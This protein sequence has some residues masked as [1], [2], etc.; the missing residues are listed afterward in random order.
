MMNVQL[1]PIYAG[2]PEDF[3][4]VGFGSGTGTNLREC[5]KVIKPSLIVCDRPKADLL[6]LEELAEVPRIVINGYER[7]GSWKKAQGNPDA[8]AAY[9]EKS[10]VLDR[11]FRDAIYEFEGGRGIELHLAVLGGWMRFI[12]A[13]LLDYF[14][15]RMINVHPARLDILGITNKR[16]FVGDDAVYLAIK[17]GQY[18]TRSSVIIVDS[19]E[20]HGEILVHGPELE[21]DREIVDSYS[22]AG[23]EDK[24]RAYCRDHQNRQK[25]VSDWPALTTA[26]Q[27]IAQGRMALGTENQYYGEWRAVY[28]DG[29]MMPYEGFKAG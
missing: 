7:T 13:P 14:H 19:Q 21:V 27:L 11:E 22:F 2:D 20:D 18:K 24:L 28:V 25:G 1:K 17:S 16:P 15:D 6:E 29:K 5:A 26:L 23:L 12:R 9:L 3:H 4:W 10:L 8:E